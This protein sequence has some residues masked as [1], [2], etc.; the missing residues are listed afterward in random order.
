[1][2]QTR[3]NKVSF[4]SVSIQKLRRISLDQNLLRTLDLDVGDTLDVILMVDTG[5]IHLR[6]SS[7]PAKRAKKGE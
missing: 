6:K 1:M 4:G 2:S 3:L 5:E 7:Q